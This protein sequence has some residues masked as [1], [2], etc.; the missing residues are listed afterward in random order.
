MPSTVKKD[1]TMAAVALKKRDIEAAPK[2]ATINLRVTDQMLSLID[3]AAIVAG[4]TRSAFMLESAQQR[5]IDVLL[6][7]KIFLLND[8][9]HDAFMS[10]LS[11]PPQSLAGL[12]KLMAKKAPWQ[13]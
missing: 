11:E 12:R 3:S 13:K 7:Q 5:A 1:R 4:K 8:V 6:D 9:Q 2:G 10:A